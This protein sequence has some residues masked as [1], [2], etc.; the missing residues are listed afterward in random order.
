MKDYRKEEAII[1]EYTSSST[2]EE[3]YE[4]EWNTAEVVEL[5]RKASENAVDLAD[6]S[7]SDCKHRHDHVEEMAV[8]LRTDCNELFGKQSD[9]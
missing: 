9:C 6:V 5:M 1:K 8:V 4:R 2:T 3:I 7:N